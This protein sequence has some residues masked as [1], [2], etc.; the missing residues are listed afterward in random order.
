MSNAVVGAL[1]LMPI[2]AVGEVP[3]WNMAELPTVAAP[4][5]SGKKPVVP[6]PVIAAAGGTSM[7]LDIVASLFAVPLTGGAASTK[8][9][10][11]RPPMVSA[12]R[13][14]KA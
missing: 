14:F 5:K 8:A 13:A 6:E 3:D 4:V 7:P 12:S 9:E 2:F 10:G 11:G 1:V